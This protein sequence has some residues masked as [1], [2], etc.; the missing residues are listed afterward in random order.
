MKGWLKSAR[1]RLMN[2]SRLSLV[3]A[4]ITHSPSPQAADSSINVAEVGVAAL[5]APRRHS[6]SA[7]RRHQGVEK[8]DL[9]GYTA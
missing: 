3:D 4:D 9:I 5:C 1:L 7:R 6:N 2:E 8:P